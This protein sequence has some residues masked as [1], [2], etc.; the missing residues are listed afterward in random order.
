LERETA[1]K[2]ATLED[3]KEIERVI[4]QTDNKGDSEPSSVQNQ[5]EN[6]VNLGNPLDR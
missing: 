5:V 6:K 3:R 1:S 4:R 2:S